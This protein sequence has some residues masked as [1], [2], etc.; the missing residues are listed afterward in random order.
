[1]W[2]CHKAAAAA[3]RGSCK[4]IVACSHR[5][6]LLLRRCSGFT[7][8]SELSE[9]FLRPSNHALEILRPARLQAKGVLARN[10]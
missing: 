7:D 8:G 4:S 2:H 5:R 1:M 10:M 3:G 6:R 9:L